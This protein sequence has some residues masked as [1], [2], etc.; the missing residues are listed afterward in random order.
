VGGGGRRREKK[1]KKR[2]EKS[3]VYV[4]EKSPQVFLLS[5]I[6]THKFQVLFFSSRSHY[7]V[8]ISTDSP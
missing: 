6:F 1:E 7:C 8:N 5:I 4:R 2:K 3:E